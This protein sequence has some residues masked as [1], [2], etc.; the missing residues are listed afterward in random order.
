MPAIVLNYND[1]Y[2]FT[3][4]PKVIYGVKVVNV[5]VDRLTIEKGSKRTDQ[6][7]VLLFALTIYTGLSAQ[8]ELE[9]T[10]LFYES[11]NQSSRGERNIDTKEELKSASA[12]ISCFGE[13]K[14]MTLTPLSLRL[15]ID[16]PSYCD[17]P[18]LPIPL[19]LRCPAY[20]V[21]SRYLTGSIVVDRDCQSSQLSLDRDARF[22]LIYNRFV[23]C[24]IVLSYNSDTGTSKCILGKKILGTLID[25]YDDILKKDPK[26]KF[27]PVILVTTQ[28]YDNLTPEQEE[29]VVEYQS[30]EAQG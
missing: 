24:P 17:T 20:D 27:M 19:V 29:K 22:R 16:L 11:F 21:Y 13:Y 30:I 6:N 4:A 28:Q 5:V 25:F 12:I 23:V 7:S 15:M 14:D 18:A 9:V 2:D 26:A 10:K 3:A 1:C 8:K